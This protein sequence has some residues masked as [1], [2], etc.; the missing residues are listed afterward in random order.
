VR[1]RLAERARSNGNDG[2][3]RRYQERARELEH[4]AQ[5]VR[6]LV[7]AAWGAAEETPA[8]EAAD[9]T[10]AAIEEIVTDVS[11]LT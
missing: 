11:R 8:G 6:R 1:R 2:S 5:Q 3:V 9:L 4:Q 10:A 7:M